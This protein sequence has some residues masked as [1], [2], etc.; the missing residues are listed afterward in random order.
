MSTGLTGIALPPCDTCRLQGYDISFL[1][2]NFHT[3]AMYK[4]KIVDF[5]VQFMEDIDKEISSMKL[6][7]NGATPLPLDLNSHPRVVTLRSCS[8]RSL[9]SHRSTV[10]WHG[11]ACGRADGGRETKGLAASGL[12]G[13][14]TGLKTAAQ[15]VGAGALSAW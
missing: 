14:A 2:T 6:A 11:S 8:A 3:E 9:G 10:V 13:T 5:I 7:V 12:G 15:A 1:V 4:H